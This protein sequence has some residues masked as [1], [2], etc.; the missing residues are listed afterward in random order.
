MADNGPAGACES[1]IT[2]VAAWTCEGPSIWIDGTAFG[3]GRNRHSCRVLRTPSRC[4]KKL[5]RI[6]TALLNGV[7]V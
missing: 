1:S 7:A 6:S 3:T 4:K 2:Y 5:F